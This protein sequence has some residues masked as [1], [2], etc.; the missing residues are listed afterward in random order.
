MSNI[1]LPSCDLQLFLPYVFQYIHT[2]LNDA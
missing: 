2:I 1:F